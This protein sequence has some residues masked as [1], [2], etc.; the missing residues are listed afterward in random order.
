[1]AHMV[2]FTPLLSICRCPRNPCEACEEPLHECIDR[3]GGRL[4]DNL[5]AACGNVEAKEVFHGRQ[6]RSLDSFPQVALSG[7]SFTGTMEFFVGKVSL[8]LDEIPSG[9]PASDLT[10]LCE[11]TYST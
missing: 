10:S 9:G 3:D 4:R 7:H 5:A 2:H 1:M 8:H 11:R 6:V